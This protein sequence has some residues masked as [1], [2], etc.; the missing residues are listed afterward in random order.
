MVEPNPTARGYSVKSG[1]QLLM[2]ARCE[3]YLVEKERQVFNN[4]SRSAQT[5][6]QAIA[7][8]GELW[9]RARVVDRSKLL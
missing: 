9:C 4:Q 3:E 8:L 1:F 2:S 7:D 5:M 6:A